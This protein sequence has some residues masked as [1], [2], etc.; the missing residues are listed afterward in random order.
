M[1]TNERR[2][3]DRAELDLIS[4]KLIGCAFEVSNTL[5][6]GFVEKV[7]EN[8]LAVELRKVGLVVEQQCPMKVTYDGVVVGEFAADLIIERCV[9]VEL[10]AAAALDES[11]V[12]QCLNY[13]KAT[14]LSVCLLLNFGRP[15]L[16]MKRVVNRF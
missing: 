14:G 8:A 12:A 4:E 6:A 15:R 10:K 16:Q 13:L 2:C 11:H 5:G 9:M 7:Y 1:S 3:K